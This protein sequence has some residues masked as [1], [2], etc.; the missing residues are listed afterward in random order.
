LYV[1]DDKQEEQQIV[2]TSDNKQRIY[3]YIKDNPGTHLRKISQKLLIAMGDIQYL[4]R[5]KVFRK[6]RYNKV[7]TYMVI[8]DI[9][10]IFYTRR[11]V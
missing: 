10:Y 4:E 1:D 2:S 8:Q 3:S 6:I 11:E 7:A 9:L 5:L